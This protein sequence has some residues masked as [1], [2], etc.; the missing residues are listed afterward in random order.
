MQHLGHVY[1]K[2]LLV[3][4]LRLKCNWISCVVSAKF[5]NPRPLP[6]LLIHSPSDG[7]ARCFCLVTIANAITTDVP[8]CT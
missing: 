3:A 2:K 1:T 5:G 7:Q 6:T 4:Y 8:V